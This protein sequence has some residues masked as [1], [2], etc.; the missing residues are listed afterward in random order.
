MSRCAF[1]G[2][3][4]ISPVGQRTGQVQG[5][6]RAG[7]WAETT[8]LAQGSCSRRADHRRGM[9]PSSL[10]RIRISSKSRERLRIRHPQ[11]NCTLERFHGGIQPKL[12]WFFGIDEFAGTTT[13]VHDSLNQDTLEIPRAFMCN[14]PKVKEKDNATGELYHAD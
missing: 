6:S 8:A 9:H 3:E 10:P 2:I 4:I 11:T 1:Y 13:T 7:G 12:K 5:W 14:I